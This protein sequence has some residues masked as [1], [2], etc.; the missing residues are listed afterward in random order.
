MF[1]HVVGL[2]KRLLR[3]ESGL[4]LSLKPGSVIVVPTDFDH[5]PGL[6]RYSQISTVAF[7]SLAS[8]A[9]FLSIN[10]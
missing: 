5:Q 9:A 1:K 6:E 3:F 2:R 8:I 7:Q 4:S 10:D